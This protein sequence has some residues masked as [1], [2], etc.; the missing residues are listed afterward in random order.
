MAHLMEILRTFLEDCGCYDLQEAELQFK[1]Q[2]TYPAMRYT[3]DQRSSYTR[4]YVVG[5]LPPTHIWGTQPTA[6]RRGRWPTLYRFPDG[7][8]W[9]IGGYLK[10][11][12][13]RQLGAERRKFYPVGA[14]FILHHYVHTLLDYPGEIPGDVIKVE[15]KLG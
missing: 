2:R 3:Q 11:N 10:E 13:Y 7:K 15:V 5:E 1:H 9:Y 8:D 6:K 14:Y 4:W 12:M